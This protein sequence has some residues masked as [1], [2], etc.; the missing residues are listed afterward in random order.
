MVNQ[1]EEVFDKPKQVGIG[2]VS[3]ARPRGAMGSI[4]PTDS[5]NA[6]DVLAEDNPPTQFDRPAE[7]EI[8]FYIN[9]YKY[10]LSHI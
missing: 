5:T 9:N 1:T 3:S 8:E 7:K 6:L 10:L 2:S 4:L